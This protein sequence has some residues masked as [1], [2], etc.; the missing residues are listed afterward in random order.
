ML[1][2][3]YPQMLFNRE[4]QRI[5]KSGKLGKIL[6]AEGEYNHPT[7]DWDTEFTKIYRFYPEHWRHFLPRTYY[8]THSLGPVMA[9]TGATPKKV[10]AFA[11]FAPT[12]D[13]SP[14]ASYVGDQAANITTFNDD[15][16]VFRITACS[17]HGGHHNA[18]LICGT[19]GQIEN[20]RG[21]GEQV[22]LRYNEWDK[23]EGEDAHQSYTPS[24][25]DKDE[26]LIKQTGHG[27][28]DYITARIFIES[29]QKGEQPPHPF[30]I[31]SA[32][33]MSSTGILG[34]RSVMEGGKVY[35]I[36]DF[37]KEEDCKLYE[38]DFLT[39]FYGYNGEK[40]TLPCCSHP[41][42]KPTE[43]NMR[44]YLEELKK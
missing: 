4:M 34:F 9:A 22:M 35:D 11:M 10:T 16:S 7:S 18:Y 40:P 41:D 21:M 15:G 42:Y 39:P 44:L 43:E 2:E 33:A 38:N 19:K 26:E 32:V 13:D 36:P 1:A 31:Y 3:N 25:N 20:L 5:A 23:P 24:W 8:I 14:S 12:S 17:A 30:D 37:R 27:G 29:L 28:G 6:Y